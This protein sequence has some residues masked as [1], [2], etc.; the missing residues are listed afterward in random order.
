MFFWLGFA[1][2]TALAVFAVLWPL[3][4]RAAKAGG[5]DIAV[6][7]SQLSEIDR[8]RAA[9]LIG[10]A[11]AEAART[12][13]SRRLIAAADAAEAENARTAEP[14]QG[15]DRETADA[16]TH[17]RRRA[18]A[19][20]SLV[21][22]PVGGI[23]VYLMLG[24]PQMPGEPLAPRIAAIHGDRSVENMVAQVE[25]HIVRD[26]NDVRAYTVLVPVYMR[27]GRYDDAVNAQRRILA[28]SG[29]NAERLSDLGDAL[30]QAAN[31]VI[32]VEAKAAFQRAFALDGTDVKARFY[33]GV[34]SEQD[35]NR[36]KAAEIWR[37]LLAEAP[38]DAPWAD[39][40]RQSLAEIGSAA[41]PPPAAAA[42][43]ATVPAPAPAA[44]AA[45]GPSAQ[46]LAAV[47]AMSENERSA[48]I[49]DMVARLAGQLH[50]DGSDIEGWRRL[51]GAYMVLGERD[52]A[53]A[54]AA[55][56]RRAL[57]RDPDKLRR[58][59]DVIKGMGLAG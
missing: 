18:I 2:M 36:A 56:A 27:L 16:L 6:Y 42:P 1:L 28:L 43:A 58:I 17:L 53:N 49:R 11:E 38:P 41:S 12:E 22:L 10:A 8:D 35:G 47:A 5:S 21:L 48:M 25:A 51:L 39:T 45:P 24:S 52:K 9:G 30:T 55:D 40:V 34:A 7:R 15:R 20:A 19:F 14:A 13:V 29:E 44:S 50:Q 57:A 54:A 31:G 37:A 4:R 59:D 26:P 23:A 3:G 46:Q 33:L 32:T